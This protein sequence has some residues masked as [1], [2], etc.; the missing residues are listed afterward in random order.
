VTSHS[1]NPKKIRT[2]ALAIIR[3]SRN[4]ILVELSTD[5]V[6]RKSFYRPL[7][8]GIEFGETGAQACVREFLE[9]IGKRVE[10]ISQIGVF[11]NLFE[12]EGRLGHEIILLYHAKF[13]NTADEHFEALDVN[14]NGRSTSKAVW[15]NLEEIKQRSLPLYPEG[16]LKKLQ[17]LGF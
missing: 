5:S 2:L 16:L 14:E 7:G 1:E 12:Y 10:V 11:E 15:I 13:L 17:D 8:G 3:D 4:G 9:E 6:K